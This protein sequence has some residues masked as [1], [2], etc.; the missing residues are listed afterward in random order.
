MAH[1]HFLGT[2]SGTEPQP[3]KHHCA[4]IIEV[5]GKYYWFDA[6][7]GCAHTVHTSGMNIMNTR[8]IFISHPHIDHVGGL[9]NVLFCMNKL[10]AR[11]KKVLIHNNQLDVYFPGLEAFQAIKFLANSCNLK[12]LNRYELI[13]HEVRDGLLFEDEHVRITAMHNGHLR[14]DGSEGW[15]SFSYLIETE[16]KR[17]VF[18]GDLASPCELDPF[19]QDGCDFLIMETGHHKVEDVCEYAIS[20]GVK[21]LRFNH[22]GRDIL[23]DRPKWEKMVA[24]YAS[25]ANISIVICR[26]GMV[27]SV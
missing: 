16:G 14:E 11:E 26:D 10:N 17:I 20:R 24:D 15:H 8:A 5:G 3:G 12:K 4:L 21:K 23:S 6:G 27:E 13:E 7:E 22:H 1:V 2:L 18:S 19:M 25:S 9:A